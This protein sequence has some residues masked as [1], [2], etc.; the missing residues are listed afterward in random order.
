MPAPY[1]IAQAIQAARVLAND[2]VTSHR[3]FPD[4]LSS[5]VGAGRTVFPLSNRNIVAGTNY[6]KDGGA[7]TS[8]DSLVT[9][10]ANGIVTVSPAPTQSLEW[11]YYY[12]DFTDAEMTQYVDNG[13]AEVGMNETNLT[14]ID[15]TLYDVMAHFAAAQANQVRAERYASQYNATI[16]GESFEKSAVYNAYIKAAQDHLKTAT[17]KR[18]QFYK[19]Q[20][21]MFQ[22]S[23]VSV[24]QSYTPNNSLP[25]R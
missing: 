3:V 5:L 2:T 16:E 6:V 25:T 12:Q 17:D 20:G 1:T 24:S 11:Y 14:T 21:R 22:S 23:S 7:Y 8:G 4:S 19:R 9:D 13:L 15:P 18:E 10:F